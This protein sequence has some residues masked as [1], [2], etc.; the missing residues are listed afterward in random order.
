MTVTMTQ[1]RFKLVR[2]WASGVATDNHPQP[3]HLKAGSVPEVGSAIYITCDWEGNV[4][5]VGSVHR[6]DN[7][8]GLR[9]RLAEHRRRR[10]IFRYWT[11]VWVVELT[12]ADSDVV[13]RI[14]GAIG[15][16]L[17]PCD[18]KLLPGGRG[19]R[20]SETRDRLAEAA[21]RNQ[22]TLWQPKKRD[23]GEQGR[24]F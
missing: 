11:Q 3:Y 19:T 22:P 7:P 8:L 2:R 10:D 12:G 17:D 20:I 9:D 1:E 23:T 5:Y 18:T 15:R 14:E 13:H 16:E 24:L 6:P 21:E 4:R